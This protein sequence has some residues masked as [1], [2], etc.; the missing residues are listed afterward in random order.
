MESFIWRAA[1]QQR[2]PGGELLAW[3]LCRAALV[4]RQ[5][6]PSFQ[7]PALIAS[8]YGGGVAR[9]E[10]PPDAD[11]VWHAVRLYERA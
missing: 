1:P 11:A 2:L 3:F 4:L 6:P 9:R 8:P 5:P 10:H 7:E